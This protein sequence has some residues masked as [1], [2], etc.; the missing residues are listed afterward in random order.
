MEKN[1]NE[2]ITEAVEKMWENTYGSTDENIIVDSAYNISYITSKFIS[3]VFYADVIDSSGRKDLLIA[4]IPA[5]QS[6]AGCSS[7]SCRIP[8]YR[9][10]C[11]KYQSPE[12]I[13]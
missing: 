6:A 8:F 12:P 7:V 3:T 9:N 5:V 10:R 4:A 11:W 1:A 2:V 13:E